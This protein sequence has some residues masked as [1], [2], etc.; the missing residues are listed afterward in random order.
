MELREE[1]R[2]EQ[3]KVDSP[4]WIL[5]DESELEHTQ[6]LVLDEVSMVGERMA[7]DLISYGCPILCL[8]DPAQLPPV[9]GGGYF[10]NHAPDHLL[11]DIH[12]SALDSPVTRLATTDPQQ[13]A[14]PARLRRGRPRR[15][16]RPPRAAHPRRAAQLRPDPRRPKNAT[17]WQAVHLCAR[18]AG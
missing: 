16:L 2:R 14:G 1:I 15:R 9:E 3:A 17:R 10:I 12:R 8:G 4:D 6:L 11:T 18:C 13:P 7:K 5:K